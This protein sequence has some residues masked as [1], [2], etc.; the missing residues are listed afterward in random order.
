MGADAPIPPDMIEAA[1]PDEA[2]CAA[3]H[4]K[5]SCKRN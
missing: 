4:V 3:V 2:S 1:A 5:F